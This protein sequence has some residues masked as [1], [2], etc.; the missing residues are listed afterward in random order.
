MD[1]L[2][3]IPRRN[4]YS[5]SRLVSR[6]YDGRY[7]YALL[8][9]DRKV[10]GRT[11]YEL[12]TDL[13]SLGQEVTVYG[14]PC[15]LPLKVTPNGVVRKVYA[16]HFS[17]DSDTSSGN[18]G[19]PVVR[20]G[21]NKVVGILTAG[22]TDLQTSPN[23]KCTVWRRC[24]GDTCLLSQVSS[25]N[26]F[27]HLFNNQEISL[28]DSRIFIPDSGQKNLALK[29]AQSGTYSFSIYQEG[30]G[31]RIG[32]VPHPTP[33]TDSTISTFLFKG[34]EYLKV[35][36]QPGRASLSVEYMHQ[37]PI[38]RFYF[39]RAPDL[40]M[41]IKPNEPTDSYK[42]R[43]GK[44]FYL[45]INLDEDQAGK[46]TLTVSN[47]NTSVRLHNGPALTDKYIHFTSSYSRDFKAGKYL[48][49]VRGFRGSRQ[50]FSLTLSP[51]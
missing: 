45:R 50:R 33:P 11:P 7:D 22:T 4:I 26:T 27:Q 32:S 46:Y 29:V 35:E 41:D 37:T 23:G 20:S 13:V 40:A 43:R 17:A 28:G 18:S 14:H 3:K 16:S 24:K 10:E 1:D 30:N 44:R 21:T 15:Q 6:R 51:T 49:S 34:M 39:G 38:P 19:S 25:S 36:G 31:A 5:C 47:T 12:D 42:T 2:N 9:L 8:Q 48:L